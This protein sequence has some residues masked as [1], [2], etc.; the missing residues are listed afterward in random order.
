MTRKITEIIVHC[1]AT[2]PNWMEGK[3]LADKIAEIDRWHKQRGWSGIGYHYLIDRNGEML[4]G[5]SQNKAGAHVEGRNSTTLGICLIGGRGSNANDAPETH[6]TPDQLDML[7]RLIDNLRSV[8]GDIPVTGHN[9]YAAKACPGFNVPRWFANK[10]PRKLTESRTLV[11]QAVAGTGTAG[12]SVIELL[13][14]DVTTAQTAVQGAMEYL[15]T[16]K[17][18]FVAL[19][20]AGIA[21]TV[22]ARIDDWKRGRK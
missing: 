2:A 3:P 9:Q 19:V 1:S 8:Y 10:G 21:L 22:Y 15:P 14:S 18:L 12:A 13:A 17:W 5:R 16:L 4:P 6:Y 7:R 11:G 20:F